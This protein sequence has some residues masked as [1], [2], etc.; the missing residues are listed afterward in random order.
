MRMRSSMVAGTGRGGARANRGRVC[1]GVFSFA[2]VVLLSAGV[3]ACG[4]P[5]DQPNQAK[6]AADVL[7][8]VLH[9]TSEELART[10]IEVT[11]VVRG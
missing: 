9:L 5:S 7:P 8:G 1:R 6:A 3:V 2:L 10:V 4:K 11:S